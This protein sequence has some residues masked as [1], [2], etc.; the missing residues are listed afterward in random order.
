MILL[1]FNN[2]FI[3]DDDDDDDEETPAV[4]AQKEPAKKP[5]STPAEDG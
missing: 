1:N 3:D 5:Q 2:F 4:E